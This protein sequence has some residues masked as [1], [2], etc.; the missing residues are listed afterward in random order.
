[1]SDDDSFFDKMKDFISTTLEKVQ[2]KIKGNDTEDRKK[3]K[4]D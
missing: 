1:M 3:K 4:K 2:D